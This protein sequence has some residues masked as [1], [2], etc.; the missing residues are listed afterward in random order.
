MLIVASSKDAV[1]TSDIPNVAVEPVRSTGGSS[2]VSNS[3]ISIFDI[4]NSVVI[5]FS[6]GLVPLIVNSSGSVTGGS[7][8]SDTATRTIVSPE[9]CMMSVTLPGMNGVRMVAPSPVPS[10]EG[11]R[12][13]ILLLSTTI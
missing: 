6:T 11:M 1:L 12:R 5:C 10:V 3:I 13:I 2:F 7:W 8:P 4:P 9:S